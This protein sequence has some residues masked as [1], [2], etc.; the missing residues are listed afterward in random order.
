MS[1]IIYQKPHL[2]YAQQKEKLVTQGMIFDI[3]DKQA[4]HYLAHFNYYRLTGYWHEYRQTNN[5]FIAN[6]YFS[7]IIQLY[8]FDK[9]LR[10]LLLDAIEQIEVSV[11]AKLAYHLGASYGSHVLLDPSH[12]SNP[13]IYKR[14]L[15]KL[16][17]EV[18]R[19]KEEFI[20]HLLNK[21]QEPLP[22]IWAS[23]EVMS[24]GQLSN[25]YGNIELRKDA[26][27]ISRQ[28]KLDS[29]TLKTFLH[30][31]TVLRN[32]CA[33][34]ARVWNKVFTVTIKK[35]KNTPSQITM[36]FQVDNYQQKKIYN[37]LV[38]M[39]WMLNIIQPDHSWTHQLKKLL[40]EY[41]EINTSQ[42]G[43]PPGWQSLEIWQ[44]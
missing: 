5:S 39:A 28:F 20:H 7:K 6:T 37:T 3:N 38:M 29:T 31:L 2:T 4:E 15:K 23:V 13:T 41:P 32:H 11:R 16:K 18:S 22:A 30:H 26:L 40:L 43:F 1:K 10:L 8:K 42:M 19:S 25:W 24:L 9:E 21:Y 17:E 44:A 34:H 36:A 27:N 12:F 33:H 35:S 14:T